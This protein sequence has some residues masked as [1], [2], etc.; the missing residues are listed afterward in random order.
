MEMLVLLY[1]YTGSTGQ[2]EVHTSSPAALG[3]ST[4]LN[5]VG[6]VVQAR[7]YKEMLTS[8]LHHSAFSNHIGGAK[9]QTNYYQILLMM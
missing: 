8:F 5:S 9:V 7:H 4:F 2:L 6:H 3:G 1:R